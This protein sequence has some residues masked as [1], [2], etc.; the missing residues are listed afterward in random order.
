M[1][2]RFSARAFVPTAAF[3]PTFTNPNPEF[4][5]RTDY[6]ADSRPIAEYSPRYDSADAKVD[7]SFVV[8]VFSGQASQAADCPTGQASPQTVSGV[9][10][11]PSTRCMHPRRSV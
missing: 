9:P 6:D 8:N 11:F 2:A 5:T 3:S 10:D 7:Q 4:M 1:A